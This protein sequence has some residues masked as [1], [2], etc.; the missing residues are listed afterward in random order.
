MRQV[1]NSSQAAFIGPESGRCAR[2]W[3]FPDY[4]TVWAE[5]VDEGS[6]LTIYGRLRFGNGDQ[7]V[8]SRRIKTWMQAL[9]TLD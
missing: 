8:N 2:V 4:T 9:E 3:G 7:G 1:R 5:D 6:R